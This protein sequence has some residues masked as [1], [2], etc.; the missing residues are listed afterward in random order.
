MQKHYLTL[1]YD[2]TDNFFKTVIKPSLKKIDLGLQ[3]YPGQ[4]KKGSW[5]APF[6][7]KGGRVTLTYQTYKHA[8]G[9]DNRKL[10]RREELPLR[11]PDPNDGSKQVDMPWSEFR[12]GSVVSAMVLPPSPPPPAPP[13][14]FPHDDR[15]RVA[16]PTV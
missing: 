13:P 4:G 6:D 15:V 8:E 2:L 11:S 1:T 7:P 14:P 16:Y 12:S 10:V 3:T 5:K 9:A